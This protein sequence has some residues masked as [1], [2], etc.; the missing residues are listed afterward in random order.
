MRVLSS[1][2][3]L[4]GC[5]VIITGSSGDESEFLLCEGIR[6]RRKLKSFDGSLRSQGKKV[7]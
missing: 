4:G 1:D 7:L 5:W 6:L 2:L 3:G